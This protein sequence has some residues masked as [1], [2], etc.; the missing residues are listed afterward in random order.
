MTLSKYHTQGPGLA[1]LER[2]LSGAHRQW[3]AACDEPAEGGAEARAAGVAAGAGAAGGS[4]GSSSNDGA[5]DDS[6]AGAFDG[7]PGLMSG[8]DDDEERMWL[9]GDRISIADIAVADLV[10]ELVCVRG[11]GGGWR[12]GKKVCG[13][14][15]A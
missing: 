12:V 8:G 13:Y 5:A 9:V 11:G 2:L 6:T 10:S 3:P 15:S 7:G 4:S 1:C 14:V